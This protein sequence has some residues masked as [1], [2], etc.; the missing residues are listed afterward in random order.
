MDL[1]EKRVH[2]FLLER[3]SFE[4]ALVEGVQQ[5]VDVIA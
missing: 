3:F 1:T 5:G 2:Y 4:F